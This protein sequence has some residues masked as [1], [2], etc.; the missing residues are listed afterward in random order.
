MG[1]DAP[2]TTCPFCSETIPQGAPKCPL[3]GEGLTARRALGAG[4][5]S[6]GS[7]EKP[8]PIGVFGILGIAF[9]GLGVVGVL[10]NVAMRFALGAGFAAAQQPF[11]GMQSAGWQTYQS[12]NMVVGGLACAVQLAAGVG[13]LSFREWGRKLMV[14]VAAFGLAQ[15]VIGPAILAALIGPSLANQP[16]ALA[17]IL[18]GSMLMGSCFGVLYDGLIIYFLGRPHVRAAIERAERAAGRT[19]R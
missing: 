19:S 13:L 11:P 6:W 5:A 9:G 7:P 4:P 8:Y 14:Y 3:C 2:T 16:P 18:I 10:I 1:D 15:A 12:V 17:G